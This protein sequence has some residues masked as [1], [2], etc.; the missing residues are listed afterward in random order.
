MSAPRQK[1]IKHAQKE[2][3]LLKEISRLFLQVTLD[4]PSLRD[5]QINRVKLSPDKGLCTVY[6]YAQGGEKAFNEKRKQLVLY[7][8]A[9]RHAL[10]QQI[11]GRYTPD[12]RFKYDAN[13]EKQLRIESL[14]ESITDD[15]K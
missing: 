12:L 14:L 4:D 2:A 10:A 1:N 13:F 15:E 11:P 6:F 5:I 7:K 3:L 8:P 9:L